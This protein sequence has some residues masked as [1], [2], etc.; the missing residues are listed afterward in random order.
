MTV[1]SNDFHLKEIKVLFKRM[2]K[3]EKPVILEKNIAENPYLRIL[4]YIGYSYVG[5]T[6]DQIKKE[7]GETTKFKKLLKNTI[8]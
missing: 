3:E 2:K 7:V 5:R 8:I 1:S 4:L 6:F